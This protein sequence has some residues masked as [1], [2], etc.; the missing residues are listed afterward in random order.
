[1][2]LLA[3][4]DLSRASG[5]VIEA[6]H[7]VATAIDAD[8]FL[9][10]VVVPLP[11]IAGPEFHPVMEQQDLSERYLDEQDQL[12]GLVKQLTEAG[13]NAKAL[14]AQGDPVKAIL[15]EAKRLDAELIVVGSHG[16]GLLFDAL[17]GSVSAGLLRKSPLPVLIVPI[18]GL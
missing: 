17:V 8:V 14:I 7:R 2:K 12:S 13:V 11:S 6:I 9:V 3:A 15:S 10:H 18:R 1:M 4:V 16:H 5:Y